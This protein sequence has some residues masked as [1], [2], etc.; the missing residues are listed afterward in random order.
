MD[1]AAFRAAAEAHAQ[2]PGAAQAPAP[3]E[4][5]DG[6]T[7][8]ALL[9]AGHPRLAR[10]AVEL[11]LRDAV[12]E[13]TAR[14][15]AIVAEEGLGDLDARLAEAADPLSRARLAEEGLQVVAAR[16]TAPAAKA[17]ERVRGEVRRLGWPSARALWTALGTDV[18]AIEAWAQRT[19]A[20]GGEPLPGAFARHDLP[21]VRRAPW[22]DALLPPGRAQELLD[23][24]VRELRP[25]MAAPPRSAK[26]AAA[27]VPAAVSLFRDA[28]CA[29]AR[30]GHA[31]PAAPFERR[32]LVAPAELEAAALA[33]EHELWRRGGP[34]L[35]GHGERVRGLDTRLAA[36]A[37]LHDLELLEHGPVEALRERYARR[38]AAATGLD[39]PSAPWLDAADPLLRS[40][41]YA[42]ALSTAASTD[43]RLALRFS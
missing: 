25:G 36:A 34:E 8:D 38:A 19:V 39:W 37:V 41:D 2:A 13:P 30:A 35:T 7:I 18:A 22:A 14:R 42:S 31:D 10:H 4:L 26:G 32:A 27:G 17:V 9:D 16:L 3:A 23:E 5:T 15:A 43:L 21:R 12:A 28:G 40:L 1:V 20:R 29:L 6:P 24:V 11:R 33:A